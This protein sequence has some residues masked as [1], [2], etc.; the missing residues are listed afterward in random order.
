MPHLSETHVPKA[1][2]FSS[3]ST[4]LT[5][6]SIKKLTASK[7]GEEGRAPTESYPGNRRSSMKSLR[8]LLTCFYGVIYLLLYLSGSN[9]SKFSVCAKGKKNAASVPFFSLLVI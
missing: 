2:D 8:R 6:F 3:I 5:E 9:K 7:Q 4:L 1:K